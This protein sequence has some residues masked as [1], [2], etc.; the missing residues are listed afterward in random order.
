M[1]NDGARK[2]INKSHRWRQTAMAVAVLV[3]LWGP[4][5]TA[6][7]LGRVAVRSALGEPLRAE[8]EVLSISAEEAASLKTVVALPERFKAAGLEYNPAL[9]TLQAT[10]QRSPDGRAY[11]HLISERV[12]SEPFVDLILETTWASGRIV[13]DYTLLFDPPNPRPVAAAA[14]TPAQVTVP[15]PV[16]QP[17]SAAA[18][19]VPAMPSASSTKRT[20]EAPKASAKTPLPPVAPKA[21]TEGTRQ[22]S[23][24][25]GDTASRIAAATK[26]ENVSLDQMLVALLRA[27]PHA[28]MDDNV[29]RIKAGSIIS[30]PAPE[31]ALATPPTQASQIIVAQSRDFNG[32]RNKLAASAPDATMAA[33][34]HKAIGTIQA[35]VDDKKPLASAPDRLTLSKGAVQTL[36]AQDQLAKERAAK[37]VADRAAEISRNISDL[38]KLG[39]ASSAPASVPTPVATAPS[40]ASS[41]VAPQPV[42]GTSAPVPAASV[43]VKRPP[44]VSAPAPETGLFDAL[45]E[46][47]LL[48]A[49]A[50]G[51]IALLALLGFYRRQQRQSDAQLDSIM[52]EHRLRPD[53]YFAVSGGQS[54]DTHDGVAGPASVL[55]A[56]SQ[57]SSVEDADPVAE[58][59]VYL[60]YGRDLQAEEILKDAL[61]ANPERLAIH[62]KLLDLFAKRHDAKSFERIAKKAFRIT[63]GEGAE[64]QRMRE[65]GLSIDADNPRYQPGWKAPESEAAPSAPAALES[66]GAAASGTDA[67][68][69]QASTAPTG[70]AMELDLD[71]DFSLDEEPTDAPGETS[72]SV[73]PTAPGKLPA[74]APDPQPEAAQAQHPAMLEF[75]LG[76]LSLELEDSTEASAESAA[77]VADDPL[78]TKMELAHEFNAIGDA[79]GARAL[80]QEVID[81]ASGDMKLKAQ[82]ALSDLRSN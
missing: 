39:A 79:D 78:T 76:S 24:K 54:I 75:D 36:S 42:A 18:P 70:G 67:A 9:S 73:A 80:L 27:N 66:P 53:T 17:S 23:V 38:G 15:A 22:V 62:Q 60:A 57:L 72:S 13:R 77:S 20:A 56:P 52:Q 8:M 28:F 82:S 58:A 44:A 16:A 4:D 69:G 61:R 19:A 50:A 46:N 48:P 68:T 31:Q 1:P 45:M 14:P 65:L 21:A 32:F 29:N 35:R 63:H 30:I 2:L 47:P 74:P 59:E 34:D 41:A 64:W 81:E 71:L 10:L 12:V 6:L 3:G 55:Y 51:L 5:A 37:E 49:A 33:P 7:S 26:Q 25:P 11:I 43:A 40:A